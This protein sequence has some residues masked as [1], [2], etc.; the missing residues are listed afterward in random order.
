MSTNRATSNSLGC[1]F[2]PDGSYNV[3]AGSMSAVYFATPGDK[4]FH[5]LLEKLHKSVDLGNL[6]SFILCCEKAC[7]NS[8]A[9]H[10]ALEDIK[11]KD[12][13]DILNGTF[14]FADPVFA[15]KGPSMVIHDRKVPIKNQVAEMRGVSTSCSTSVREAFGNVKGLH[16][17]LPLVEK[18]GAERNPLHTA[19]LEKVLKIVADFSEFDVQKTTLFFGLDNNGIIILSYLLEKLA[20]RVEYTEEVLNTLARLMNSISR[21]Y[22]QFYN[23]FRELVIYNPDTW[24]YTSEE[25]FKKVLNNIQGNAVGSNS[26]AEMR[27]DYLGILLNF[28][29]AYSAQEP[30]PESRLEKL[31]EITYMTYFE[32]I[33]HS[34]LSVLF[35]YSNGYL[36]KDKKSQF[37]QM[38]YV[39]SIL[40]KSFS[41]C[42]S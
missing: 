18:L 15:S 11:F 24:L 36:L 39:L 14:L 2:T 17:F 7:A 28:I 5:H 4:H 27:S 23:K 42:K 10:K 25:L 26:T 22:P 30:L 41:E 16:G 19:V 38:Y 35:S 21:N 8:P 40:F 32:N 13:N 3:F 12:F 6:F 20:E 1:K 34:L 37:I 33:N 9:L 29:E 31:K